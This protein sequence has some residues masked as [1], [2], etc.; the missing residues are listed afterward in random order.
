ML[1]ETVILY[2]ILNLCE[3][4]S[5]LMFFYIPHTILDIVSSCYWLVMVY[6]IREFSFLLVGGGH[7]ILAA[8]PCMGNQ[9][10]NVLVVTIGL[11][12]TCLQF[13]NILTILIS[14]CESS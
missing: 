2:L 11:V 1:L 14:S 8:E 3:D 4:F 6:I 12:S 7:C 9:K 10:D 13:K 5:G